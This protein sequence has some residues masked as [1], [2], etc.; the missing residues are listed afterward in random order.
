[1]QQEAQNK[2]HKGAPAAA[3]KKKKKYTP[4]SPPPIRFT[5]YLG[6]GEF[7]DRAIA[8]RIDYDWDNETP[9]WEREY[10]PSIAFNGGILGRERYG[11]CV[12]IKDGEELKKTNTLHNGRVRQIDFQVLLYASNYKPVAD[13]CMEAGK[14]YVLVSQSAQVISIR[15]VFLAEGE[16]VTTL[17]EDRKG[18]TARRNQAKGDIANIIEAAMASFMG[19]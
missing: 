1:M 14:R 8:R 10:P 12:K 2:Q 13:N 6:E 16:E 7:K 19:A 4:P 3:P 18:W 15:W 5:P 9:M 17:S 11:L